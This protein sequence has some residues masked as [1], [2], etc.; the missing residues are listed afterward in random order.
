M[1]GGGI[2]KPPLLLSVLALGCIHFH[3]T[4]TQW[5]QLHALTKSE[6]ENNQCL[7]QHYDCY[8]LFTANAINV[9]FVG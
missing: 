1:G 9:E 7:I 8:L 2:S 4:M 6:Q 3:M 5:F